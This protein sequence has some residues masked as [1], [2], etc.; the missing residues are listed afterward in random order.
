MILIDHSRSY[1]GKGMYSHMVGSTIKELHQ[2]AESLGIKRCHFSN[3]KGK[4][5]PHYD[6]AKHLYNKCLMQGALPVDSKELKRFLN[7]TYKPVTLL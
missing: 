1:P 6:I 3:K 5:Q 4:Y 2:F 7:E